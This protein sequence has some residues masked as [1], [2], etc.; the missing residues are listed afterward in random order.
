MKS[1]ITQETLVK[2][3]TVKY[4]TNTFSG[5][6]SIASDRIWTH[7]PLLIRVGLQ[8]F[9]RMCLKFAYV[10]FLIVYFLFVLRSNI[11]YS[12][13]IS[14]MPLA[15]SLIFHDLIRIKI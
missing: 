1:E 10:L 15:C 8:T 2:F 3:F 7:G 6:R 4:Y 13:V 14:L 11:T 12:F 5:Y 9:I